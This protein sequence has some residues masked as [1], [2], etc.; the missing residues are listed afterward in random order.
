M[1]RDSLESLYSLLHT[2]IETKKLAHLQRLEK[3]KYEPASFSKYEWTLFW[4]LY[5][6]STEY[7]GIE[8]K[9]RFT[10]KME[11]NRASE[12][13]NRFFLGE[14]D[15]PPFTPDL[16]YLLTNKLIPDSW[17]LNT[18][19]TSFIRWNKTI[20]IYAFQAN[21]KLSISELNNIKDLNQLKSEFNMYAMQSSTFD[22]NYPLQ[23]NELFIENG[24]L[25]FHIIHKGKFRESYEQV[26]KI[27]LNDGDF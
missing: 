2:Y 23:C 21:Y 19:R 6:H 3:K 20:S 4:F 16:D 25:I 10:E 26:N 11:Q 15:I 12:N 1:L 5:N 13:N 18:I 14:L 7:T 17:I 8:F 24:Y 9:K 27:K 22:P